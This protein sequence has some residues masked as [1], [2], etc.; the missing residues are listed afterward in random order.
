[1]LASPPG[2]DARGLSPGGSRTPRD[3]I[4]FLRPHPPQRRAVSRG[5][6]VY[7]A[8]SFPCETGRRRDWRPIRACGD[9]RANPLGCPHRLRLRWRD[10]RPCGRRC[11]PSASGLGLGSLRRQPRRAPL[12]AASFRVPSIC[13]FAMDRINLIALA[14]ACSLG[15]SPNRFL[16]SLSNFCCFSTCTF[17]KLFARVSRPFSPLPQLHL[18]SFL[19]SFSPLLAAP[20]PHPPLGSSSLLQ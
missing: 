18:S 8:L 1:M 17:R 19:L 9:N 7:G 14:A 4:F 13:S 3:H 2:H 6:T 16:T 5:E 20:L 12:R 10:D 11:C 15:A